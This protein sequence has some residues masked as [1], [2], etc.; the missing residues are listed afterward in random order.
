[1]EITPLTRAITL[2]GRMADVPTPA[3]DILLSLI[4]QLDESI[5][6]A[7]AAEG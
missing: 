6:K 1:M 4:S 7:R 3:N 2:L 5:A